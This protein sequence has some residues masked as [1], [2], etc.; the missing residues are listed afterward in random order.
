VLY[1]IALN[2]LNRRREGLAFVDL[3]PYLCR[4]ETHGPDIGQAKG[5]HD[6]H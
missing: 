4:D 6:V 5:A 3:F 2:P 1:N